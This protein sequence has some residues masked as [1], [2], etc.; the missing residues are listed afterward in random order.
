MHCPSRAI[1][2]LFTPGQGVH[3]VYVSMVPAEGSL[4]ALRAATAA[5]EERRA[6]DARAIEAAALARAEAERAAASEL[7]AAAR[8]LSDFAV[9][10]AASCLWVAWLRLG[11]P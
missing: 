1:K 5:Y 11:W 2:V 8:A 10:C 4:A 9:D 3:Q 6:A 7:N